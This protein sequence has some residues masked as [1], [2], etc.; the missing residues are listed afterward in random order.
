MTANQVAGLARA[1]SSV[2]DV[3]PEVT[4][5]HRHRIM[6]AVRQEP[7]TKPDKADWHRM[8]E[9]DVCKALG[10][11]RHTL[12][13]R[14]AS[15][16]EYRSLTVYPDRTRHYYRSDEIERLKSLSRQIK[17]ELVEHMREIAKLRGQVRSA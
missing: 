3:M 10:I 9:Y 13:K 6:Q 15:D 12:W 1:V 8:S 14:R 7:A 11:C 16:P 5:E 4:A 2:L 17:P